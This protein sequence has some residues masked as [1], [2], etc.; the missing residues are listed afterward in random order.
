MFQRLLSVKAS[1][2]CGEQLPFP[3]PR[4]SEGL[5]VVSWVAQNWIFDIL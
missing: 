1:G 4:L 5:A 2:G 3:K